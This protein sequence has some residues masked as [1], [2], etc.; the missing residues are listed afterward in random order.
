MSKIQ[1]DCWYFSITGKYWLILPQIV[2]RRGLTRFHM[3]L[4]ICQ[5]S[6]FELC[7]LCRNSSH[8]FYVEFEVISSPNSCSRYFISS[9]ILSQIHD[10]FLYRSLI[11]GAMLKLWRLLSLS[12]TLYTHRPPDHLLASS[13]YNSASNSLGNNLVWLQVTAA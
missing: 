12:C 9:V 6:N 8:I 1:V 7:N 13:K 4:Q 10:L 2:M 5:T 3:C 11:M